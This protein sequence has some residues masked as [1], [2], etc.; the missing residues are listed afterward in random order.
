[1]FQKP[2]YRVFSP[3][4][5]FLLVIFIPGCLVKDDEKNVPASMDIK[6]AYNQ[7]NLRP[8]VILGSGPAGLAAGIYGARANISTLIIEGDKPG[9]LLTETTEV[10]NWPGAKSIL[11]KNLIN[12]LK[13]QASNLGAEFLN[14]TVTSIDDTKWPFILHTQNGNEI[15]AMTLIIATGATPRKLGIPGESQYWGNGVTTCAV[16]DAAFYKDGAVVVIGGGDSAIE[17]AGVLARYAKQVTIL[18]RKGSMR[19]AAS[20]QA[21]LHEYP[22]ISITY[23]VEPKE[24]LGDKQKVTGIKLFN[25]EKNETYDMPIDGVFLAIGHEPNSAL[26]KSFLD[27]DANGYIKLKGRSQHTSK[28]G[29]F[30]AGDVEDHVYRQ[31]GVA[32]ASGIKAGLEA[33]SFL[34][35]IGFSPKIAAE[36]QPS[37]WIN[38]STKTGKTSIVKLKTLPELEGYI[39][40]QNLPVF[41]DFYTD[42]CPSCLQMLPSYESAAVQF[43]GKAVLLKVDADDAE[44]I[45]KKY[46][47]L[48]VPCLLVFKHK[49]LAA[50]FNVAMGRKELYDSIHE[51]ID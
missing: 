1:M 35:N 38:Q 39:E 33:I 6:M 5:S 3:I 32:S 28:A 25:N 24:I 46:Q 10:E 36:L 51:F 19:A 42:Y 34:D 49:K 45:V 31:A 2:F 44:D 22:N 4:A 20:G 48:K 37:F 27:V 16:C 13:A 15:R 7:K 40:K 43:A 14:D 17:E 9:G 41:V 18:V 8:I 29:I 21:R 23:H 26:V 30:A 50:R 12:D 47:I 11:G